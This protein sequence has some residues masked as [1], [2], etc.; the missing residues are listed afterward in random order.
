MHVQ[1]CAKAMVVRIV[2]CQFGLGAESGPEIGPVRFRFQ[3]KQNLLSP[4][5]LFSCFFDY[6][7]A[8]FTKPPRQAQHIDGRMSTSMQSPKIVRRERQWERAENAISSWMTIVFLDENNEKG[9]SI[10]IACN[11]KCRK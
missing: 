2:W 10:L 4:C 5:P 8:A 7:F 11:A 9:D 3:A 1:Y 6:L